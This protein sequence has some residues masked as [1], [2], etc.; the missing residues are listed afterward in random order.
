MIDSNKY[1]IVVIETYKIT[2][3]KQ[4]R[5]NRTL[6]IK[7]TLSDF[8]NSI[9]DKK[10][11]NQLQKSD[12]SSI[13]D[14]RIGPLRIEMNRE[15]NNTE[16]LVASYLGYGVVRLFKQYHPEP[17]KDNNT[18]VE[19]DD[20]T[21]A[22]VSIPNYFTAT[23]LLG[24]LGEK[25]VG[26]LSHIRIIKSETPKRNM[27]LLKF[28]TTDTA[29]SFHEDFN[30]VRF[31]SMESENCHIVFV[32]SVI[33]RPLDYTAESSIPYLL[34]DPF[35][36]QSQSSGNKKIGY[37][38]PTIKELPTCPVCLERMDSDVTGLL[39]ICC[40]H[41]FH[42]KCLS[43]WRDDT[44][45]VCRYSSLKS[46]GKSFLSEDLKCSVCEGTQNLWVC[47][48]CGNVGCGRYDSKHAIDH[49]ERSNHCFAMDASTQRVWDYAGDNYVHRLLQNE[50][51]GKLVELSENSI[52]G[53]NRKNNPQD[54][55][56]KDFFHQEYLEI[57]LSQL[58]SQ[59]DYY[60][61]LI[62][63]MPHSSLQGSRSSAQKTGIK[64][65]ERIKKSMSETNDNYAQQ[66][67]AL[68]VQVKELKNFKSRHEK[69]LQEEKTL[70]D[71]LSTNLASLKV[72]NEA[73][74]SENEDLQ[75]Q[76]SDLMFYLESREKLKDAN[77][78]IK[79]GTIVLQDS[80]TRA[81]KRTSKKKK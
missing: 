38:F 11:L 67:K 30:G 23:D 18:E 66:I 10:L 71:N 12:L 14:Y 56:K 76:I 47:L 79:N 28:K 50:E 63:E 9:N 21:V 60:E 6:N 77:D 27:V 26:S 4:G 69:K 80:R 57:V 62:A 72:D 39:T 55:N 78:D 65:D 59:R 25:Y 81:S 74:K 49:Y 3:L 24:F 13:Q 15:K 44:C 64:N 41:T 68:K 5:C 70:T 75:S 35:T 16:Q 17:E 61:S 51:D 31:S 43:K 48:I 46:V 32:K 53:D 45:P 8:S 73:L 58:E 7:D 42:F 22:I 37:R 40:Q 36:L 33:F 2:E 19:L 52:D 1:Y 29:R 20:T 54:K 34:E